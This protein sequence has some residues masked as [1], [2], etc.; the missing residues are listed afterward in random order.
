MRRPTNFDALFFLDVFFGLINENA[1]ITQLQYLFQYYL[2]RL[3]LPTSKCKMF[4]KYLFIDRIFD[5]ADKCGL[6]AGPC[7]FIHNF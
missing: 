7:S 4:L 3:V 2:L 5:F 6:V 1:V